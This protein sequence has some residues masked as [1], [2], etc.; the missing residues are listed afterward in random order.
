MLSP[1]GGKG[2]VD[3][4]AIG[5]DCEQGGFPLSPPG[6]GLLRAEHASVLPACVAHG[7]RWMHSMVLE[8]HACMQPVSPSLHP[9]AQRVCA[10]LQAD[11]HPILSAGAGATLAVALGSGGAGAGRAV[12][13][14]GWSFSAN[15]LPDQAPHSPVAISTTFPLASPLSVPSQPFVVVNAHARSSSHR[16]LANSAAPC[17][18]N[19]TSAFVDP[20]TSGFPATSIDPAVPTDNVG[21]VTVIPLGVT[22][23][24]V[25]RP[26]ASASSRTKLP[27]RP[28]EETFLLPQA[29]STV[30]AASRSKKGRMRRG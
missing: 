9:S 29:P 2:G 18:A 16:T 7:Q 15:H 21:V 26:G 6:A 22:W 11:M 19:P 8:P 1:L 13:G 14:G 17:A 23:R 24:R 25:T 4:A 30:T 27:T 10:S 28:A 3:R 12:A 20:F 5:G